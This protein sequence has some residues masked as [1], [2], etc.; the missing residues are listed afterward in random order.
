MNPQESKRV[1]RLVKSKLR[2]QE[3]VFIVGFSEKYITNR[4]KAYVASSQVVFVYRPGDLLGKSVD[5][6]SLILVTSREMANEVSRFDGKVEIADIGNL[7]RLLEEA[8]AEPLLLSEMM[9]EEPQKL[10]AKPAANEKEKVMVQSTNLTTGTKELE[11]MHRLARR[12][13]EL[14]EASGEKGVGSITLSK[15][16]EEMG[17]KTKQSSLADAGWFETVV[18]E[19]KTQ[20]GG[21]RSTEKL[22]AKAQE[23]IVGDESTNPYHRAKAL[24]DSEPAIRERIDDL[25]VQLA[26]AKAQLERVAAAK[27]WL[28]EASKF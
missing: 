12:F 17:I 9:K 11:P 13:I 10:A 14:E 4:M 18:R 16:L 21:Y 20:V 26:E 22:R 3:I 15:L 8:F 6:T 5:D 27:A 23:A 19:G 28:E 25:Q 2:A 24:I 1:L 7:K